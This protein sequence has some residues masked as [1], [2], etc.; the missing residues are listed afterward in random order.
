MTFLWF[1]HPLHSLVLYDRFVAVSKCD[2]HDPSLTNRESHKGSIALKYEV[3]H[4]NEGSHLSYE[5]HGLWQTHFLATLVLSFC[6][7]WC[8]KNIMGKFKQSE[9]VHP[10]Q[11]LLLAA[12]ACE[13]LSHVCVIIHLWRYAVNGIIN[14]LLYIHINARSSCSLSYSC[15]GLSVCMCTNEYISIYTYV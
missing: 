10:I 1:N 13:V 14:L 12:L 11:Y 6:T 9:P 8:L 7:F 2:L 4:T 15:W 3:V 5:D